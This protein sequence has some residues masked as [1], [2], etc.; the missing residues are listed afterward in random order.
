LPERIINYAGNLLL[1]LETAKST[2]GTAL[3]ATCLHKFLFFRNYHFEGTNSRNIVFVG[4]ET[5][6]KEEL[7]MQGMSDVVTVVL[8]WLFM[9]A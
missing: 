6:C 7:M 4:K 1:L 2:R 9:Q 5:R 8:K 3:S